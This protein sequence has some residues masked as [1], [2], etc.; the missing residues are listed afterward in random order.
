[1]QKLWSMERCSLRRN[2]MRTNQKLMYIFV[3]LVTVTCIGSR[4][5]YTQDM[6]PASSSL[7][8]KIAA[9]GRKRVAVVDFTDLQGNSTQLGRFI[10][11]ELSIALAGDAKGFEVID[12]N[13][14]RVILQEHKL[15]SEGL[16]DPAT[17]RKLGQIAGVDTL[18]SG[19]ITPLGDS[20]HVGL[21]ALDTETAEVLAGFTFE[22][23]RTKAIDEL[24]VNGIA[25]G[26]VSPTETQVNTGV[27]SVPVKPTVAFGDLFL[28]MEGCEF[29]GAKIMCYG[30]V[31]NKSS[32]AKRIEFKPSSHLIDNSGNESRSDAQYSQYGMTIVVG[33]DRSGLFC[34][35]DKIL[36]PEI[37]LGIW[38]FGTGLAPSTSSV[39]IILDTSEGTAI[40]K[41]IHL[42]MK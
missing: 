25:N 10:A 34:C 27:D 17:A 30:H 22:I 4:V 39:S 15:A 14:I 41:N 23:P 24:L 33:T 11:E 42:I 29:Q 7:A 40:L 36:E 38:F 3:V 20:V 35:L 18:V 12:R 1:M 19:T 26:G 13:S 37:P 8:A 9:A 28:S 6:R 5:A 16:I 32:G 2:E 31:T 21:K